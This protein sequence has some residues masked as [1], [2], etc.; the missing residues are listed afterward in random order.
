MS[1]LRITSP[2]GHGPLTTSQVM[3][4]VLLATLPGVAVL[5]WFFGPGTLINILFGGAV[6]L[7]CEY[8]SLWLRNREPA[9]YLNDYSVLVTSTLLCI[10]LPPY[11]PWW[12]VTTGIL[13]SVILGKHVF[14]GLGY[15]PFNPAM[16]GYVVL[17]I[18]FPLQMSTWQAP[19]GLGEI[20]GLGDSLT[21]LLTPG[22]TTASPWPRP[23]I[24]CAKTRDCCW[25]TSTPRRPSSG[26]GPVLAGNGS[27]LPFSLAVCGSFTGAFSLV[28][29]P[30]ECC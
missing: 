6:A 23:W 29:R 9:P 1:F 26:S 13:A 25:T 4:T 14:G 5:T 21:A 7:A 12:L 30:W 20:P 8:A 11:A 18:S 3:Q 16:V 19:R 27:T 22:S 24:C 28:M 15:N 10:A 2:H 17:L